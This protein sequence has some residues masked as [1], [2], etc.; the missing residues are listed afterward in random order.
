MQYSTHVRPELRADSAERIVETFEAREVA[1]HPLFI[2][3]RAQPV[4]LGAL[5]IL[6]ANLQA[7][8]SKPFIVW[9]A[10]AIAHADDPCIASLICKQLNDELGNGEFDQIHSVLLTDFVDA[11]ETWRPSTADET[12]LAPG[13]RLADAGD[14]LFDDD[15]Y[16]MVG[17]IMTG[18]IFAKKM[19][20]CLGD[21]VRRQSLIAP[22]A[23]K[24]L[25][26]H[27][28]L[29]VDHAGDS[30]ELARLVPLTGSF[31]G[32]ARRGA[33]AQWE[34]LWRFLDGVHAEVQRAQIGD[35]S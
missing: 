1:D 9:L 28:A 32:A 15:A 12:V 29:E 30:L 22:E 10:R 19:D 20:Q 35:F 8:I 6:V 4:N 33:N 7:G 2:A 27:E 16:F 31:V 18:E 26:L 25:V 13:R 23:L 14:V 11:L 17:A 34:I 3:L 24:W 5:W 21:E